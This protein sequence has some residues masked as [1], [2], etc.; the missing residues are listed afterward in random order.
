MEQNAQEEIKAHLLQTSEEFRH[1]MEQHHEYDALVAALENKSVLSAEDELEEHRLK[2]FKLQLKD[3]ME[4][5]V[6][7][8][9]LQHVA[10]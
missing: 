1:L 9:R 3:Q 5:M 10:G 2:K 6:S 7:E 8:Y 4:K